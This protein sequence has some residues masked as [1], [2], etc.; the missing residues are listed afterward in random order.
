MATISDNVFLDSWETNEYYFN[1][2]S[3]P[4]VLEACTKT[5]KYNKD[6]PSYDTTTRG[7]F[8]AQFW[9]AMRTE[10][11]TLTTDFDCWKYDPNP[12]QH[13]LPSTW[14]FKIKCYPDGRVKK[15]KA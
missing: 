1:D 13:V 6:N 9:Q 14:A 10:F 11:I 3:D 4:R 15:F 8:Q 2:I 7:S 5:T 12:G